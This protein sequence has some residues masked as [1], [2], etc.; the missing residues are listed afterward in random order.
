[1]TE[2]E[3]GTD[4]SSSCEEI[5]QIGIDSHAT[6]YVDNG[7]CSLGVGAWFAI[8]HTIDPFDVPFKQILA[9]GNA[10]IKRWFGLD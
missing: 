7:F 9:T 6:C 8:V 10:C 4:A 2:L 3:Y 1:M 5:E